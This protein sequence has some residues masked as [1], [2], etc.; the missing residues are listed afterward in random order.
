MDR[1]ARVLERSRMST[2]RP[3]TAQAAVNGLG[4]NTAD[5]LRALDDGVSGLRPP[6]FRLPFPTVVGEVP[7]PLPSLP[8]SHASYACRQAEVGLI[9]FR[10]IEP[11]VRAAV[12]RW[13][14]D[15]VAIL[16]GTSTGGLHATERAYD[17]WRNTQEVPGDY[18]YERQHDF[19]AVVDFLADVAGIEGPAYTISTACSSSGK[20][21][22]SA[23]R[24]IDAD[25]V[26]AVVVGGI[27]TLCQMTL[28]GFRSLGVLSSFPCRPFGKDREGINIGEG[29]AFQL[30]E[31]D[32]QSDAWL[33]GA[34]ESADAYHMSSP[35][36]E[37]AGAV[38][39]MQRAMANIG[40]APDDIDYVNAHGTSTLHNDRAESIAIHT[41]LGERVPVTSTKGFTGH[42]LGAAAA[43]EAV[44]AVHA[45][46]T[47]RVPATLGA[48]PVDPDV[49]CNIVCEPYEAKLRYVLSNSF[50]F[51]G[52]N[53]S[54]LFGPPPDT[55]TMEN[56]R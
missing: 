48:P 4:A 14:S 10:E 11:A 22:A 31:R 5:V 21:H 30:I 54:L 55:A 3:I 38:A 25:V 45:L 18:V 35:H 7:G 52:S 46:R 16:A 2:P 12:E 15:R 39:A 8:E 23:L 19:N 42:T 41:L 40:L 28:R 44:F 13:G 34:G 6:T 37:G 51:G 24:L 33:L 17:A 9:A 43:T 56:R 20:T 50:A 29:A 1:K 49:R 32:G 36:P 26:D 27:D 47:G 53:V